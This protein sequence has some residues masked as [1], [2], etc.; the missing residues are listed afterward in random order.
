A[1]GR[2]G[3]GVAGVYGVRPAQVAKAGRD[4]EHGHRLAARAPLCVFPPAILGRQAHPKACGVPTR[5]AQSAEQ[6]MCGGG[7]VDI[8]RLG[9][10]ARGER[11]D[12]LSRESVPADLGLIANPHILEELHQ[13]ASRLA[14]AAAR[15]ANIGLTVIVISCASEESTSSNRNL[16]KPSCGRL[17]EGRVSSTVARARTL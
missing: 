13:P 10:E 8:E 17:R 2:I 12:L 16:T 14:S 1:F 15:R 11:L 9:I 6:R 7:L 3:D 5:R 4:A